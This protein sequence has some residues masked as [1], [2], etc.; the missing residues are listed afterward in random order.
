[1]YKADTVLVNSNYTKQRANRLHG[2]FDNAKVC[3]LATE[4]DD[5][6]VNCEPISNRFPSVL[7]VGRLVRGRDKGHAAL[8]KVWP[9]VVDSIPS[10]V[11]HVVGRGPELEYFRAMVDQSVRD[12]IIFHGFLSEQD[13]ATLYSTSMA[14]AMPSRSEGFG[15]VYIESMRYGLP[16]VASI[17]DAAGEVVKDKETGY[18]VDLDKPEQLTEILICLL[19]DNQLAQEL[20][21]RGQLRWKNHYSMSAFRARFQP[22]LKKFLET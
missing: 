8:I 6:P 14:L 16:V 13:L 1:M 17:H 4:S 20:G 12:N 9:D 15:L 11:L 19:K 7:T 5:V 22:I 21:S 10:A 2:G 18:T 3:W